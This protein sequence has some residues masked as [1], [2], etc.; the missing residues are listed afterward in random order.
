MLSPYRPLAM[1]AML[2]VAVIGGALI[3]RLTAPSGVGSP[4]T[5]PAQTATSERLVSLEDY[6]TARNAICN[7]STP[8]VQTLI[9][10]IDKIYDPTLTA[11]QRAPKVVALST[12]ASVAEQVVRDLDRLDVP[13]AIAADHAAQLAYYR[14]TIAL[15][16][17][18]VDAIGNGDLAGAQALDLATD[19]NSRA[20]EG[21][22]SKYGLAACP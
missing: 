8:Q 9:G 11:A 16:R 18:A 5:T 3:G 6:R 22:E 19:P 15:I 17:Q 21:F 4:V 12:I 2:V 20:I 14:S 13:T 10:Q 1:A 7:A